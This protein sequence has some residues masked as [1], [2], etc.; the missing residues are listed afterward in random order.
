MPVFPQNY[1]STV[2]HWQATNRGPGSLWDHGRTDVL[3]SDADIVIVGA[4]ATGVSLAYHLTRPGMEKRRVVLLDAKDVASCASGRNGGHIGP[5]SWEVMG[6]LTKPLSHGGGG[7]SEEDALDVL[8]FE[9][10]TL[11]LCELIV[12]RERLD[13]DFWRGYR[14]V[15]STTPE[16]VEE[17]KRT[18]DAYHRAI[19]RSAKHGDKR[20]DAS[21]LFDAGEA[22]RVSRVKGALGMKWTP[23]GSW[24]PHRG[25][26]AL[27]KKALE[28]KDMSFYSWAPVASL[29]EYRG[30][31]TVDC[32]DR[33]VIR[34]KQV[35]LATNGY[36][37]HL[38][39]DDFAAN[40]GIA[41]HLTPYRGH[42]GLVV[43]PTTYAGD[44]SL[45]GQYGIENGPYLIQT[46]YAGIVLGPFNATVVNTFGSPRDLYGIDD[47]SVVVPK[48]REWLANYC[49]DNYVDW[50]PESEG[51]GLARAWSGIMCH[52]V[53]MRPLVGEVPGKTGMFISA[54]YNGHGMATI[55]NITRCLAQ[56]LVT[57]VR[58]HR[59]PR[60]F[61]IS[62]ER[63][64]RAAA[65]CLPLLPPEPKL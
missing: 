60:C 42:A 23:S 54:G 46:P 37:R 18:L 62:Q 38:F 27:L 50:G 35:V 64:D 11:D 55:V 24:H 5:A 48:F 63:L 32:G 58:D 33:G 10:E 1:T 29:K 41:A 36:T 31:W 12:M 53:D 8:F 28:N 57:G 13:V 61:D 56:H 47:D 51:E 59:L 3:P 21:A 45:K 25:I 9:Q 30:G 15:V 22:E 4:G 17:S 14:L 52:S 2:S 39:P 43:P 34:T 20:L 49:R 6:H 26:T 44:K 19:K 40:T 7:V 16:G 65:E